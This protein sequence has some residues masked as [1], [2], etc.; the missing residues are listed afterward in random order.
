[1]SLTSNE[2]T[3]MKRRRRRRMKRRRRDGKNTEI[4]IQTDRHTDK[5]TDS[6]TDNYITYF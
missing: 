4:Y 1:M 5:Q 3:D 2:S 6:H